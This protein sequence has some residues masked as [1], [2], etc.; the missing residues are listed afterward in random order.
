MDQQTVYKH[1]ESHRSG[2]PDQSDIILKTLH[3]NITYQDE[4]ICILKL[5]KYIIVAKILWT[6]Y[7]FWR[8]NINPYI[9]F[10][11]VIPSSSC[12]W[13]LLIGWRDTW[14]TDLSHTLRTSRS[15]AFSAKTN[16]GVKTI[17]KLKTLSKK[18]KYLPYRY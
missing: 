9:F 1:L 15:L 4:R 12:K 8:E 16:R 17:F 3:K 7:C 5:L 10:R 2:R 18:L 6:I 11:F 13:S 14:Y